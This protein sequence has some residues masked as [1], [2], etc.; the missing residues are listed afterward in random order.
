[1]TQSPYGICKPCT[2]F[3]LNSISESLSLF[4]MLPLVVVMKQ[5][6]VWTW[7]ICS[8]Q[9]LHMGSACTSLH[10]LSPEF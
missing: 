1:M 7:R 4:T 6:P 8:V 9:I 10:H 3:I 5:K 2:P